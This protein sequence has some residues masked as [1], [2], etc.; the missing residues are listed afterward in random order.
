MH[1]SAYTRH[2]NTYPNIYNPN[3]TRRLKKY[4]MVAIV[5]ESIVCPEEIHKFSTV[6]KC[7]V[8]NTT[9]GRSR[10]Q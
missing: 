1:S 7:G 2:T 8:P 10:C 4:A 9:K 5:N 3:P 6:N